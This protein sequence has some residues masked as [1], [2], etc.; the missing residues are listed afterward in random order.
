[1]VLGRNADLGKVLTWTGNAGLYTSGVRSG[2]EVC[3][4]GLEMVVLHPR[5]QSKWVSVAHP[6]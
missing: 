3:F 5:F 4:S 2:N 6:T 1:M